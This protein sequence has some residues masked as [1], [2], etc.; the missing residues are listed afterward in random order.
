MV[1]LSHYLV[2]IVPLMY[3]YACTVQSLTADVS[4]TDVHSTLG[5]CTG[6][7]LYVL[8]NFE[9]CFISQKHVHVQNYVIPITCTCMC[10][11]GRLLLII[12]THLT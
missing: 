7:Y 10:L 2:T 4:H 11:I 9:S 5:M 8:V 3:S 12:M 6:M 1:V